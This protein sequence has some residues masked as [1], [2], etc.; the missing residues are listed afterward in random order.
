MQSSSRVRHRFEPVFK[1]RIT[2]QFGV[3]GDSLALA[4]RVLAAA[5]V[6]LV[7]RSDMNK[8]LS[9][10]Q[11]DG[12][13]TKGWFY[14]YGSSGVMIGNDGLTTALV[15][16]AIDAVEELDQGEDPSVRVASPHSSDRG[17]RQR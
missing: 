14:K 4:M 2:E 1:E 5:T 10:Q 17:S 12:S 7:G 9:M 16:K 8:L 11:E 6:G 13:W 3:E 15:I